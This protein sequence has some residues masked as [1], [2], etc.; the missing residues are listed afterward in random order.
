MNILITND[1]GIDVR[2]LHELADILS[3]I[4]NT[5][6]YVVAPDRQRTAASLST[7]I[8]AGLTLTEHDPG[9]FKRVEK[10]YACSG[11]PAD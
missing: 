4:P 9:E 6:I 8:F 2:G 5:K 7:T 1:D 3:E 11:Y 10:A